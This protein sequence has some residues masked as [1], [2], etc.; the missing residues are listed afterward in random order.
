MSSLSTDR[1]H[2]DQP[3]TASEAY[4][5]GYNAALAAEQLLSAMRSART[6]G[7]PFGDAEEQAF[8]EG[9]RAGVADLDGY[10]RDMEA[11]KDRAA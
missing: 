2:N 10:R 8:A 9:F 5:S 6:S 4:E 3:D 1:G 11:G 7:A